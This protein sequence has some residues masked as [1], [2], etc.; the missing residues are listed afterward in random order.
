MLQEAFS[1]KTPNGGFQT[2]AHFQEHISPTQFPKNWH[3][4]IFKT[5]SICRAR[6]TVHQLMLCQISYCS[7][8]NIFFWEN[9]TTCLEPG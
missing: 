7:K 1:P 3:P 8:G 4:V 2:K 9:L 5:K 6:V